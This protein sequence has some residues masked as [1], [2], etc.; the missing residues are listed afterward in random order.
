MLAINLL[1]WRKQQRQMIYLKI[2]SYWIFALIVAGLTLLYINHAM[3][4]RQQN[5]QRYLKELQQQWHRLTDD[6]Q[7]STAIYEATRLIEKQLQTLAQLAMHQ[8]NRIN[9]FKDIPFLIPKTIVLKK[10]ELK[11]NVLIMEG[12]AANYSALLAWIKSLKSQQRVHQPKLIRG[13]H[14]T[15]NVDL[16]FKVRVVMKEKEPNVVSSD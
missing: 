15:V 9:L 5:Q 10:I 12:L 2:I 1:N 16:A 7:Q 6:K 3:S 11:N 14:S 13:N 4:Q 8:Q